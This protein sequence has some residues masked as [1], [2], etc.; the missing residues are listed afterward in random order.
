MATFFVRSSN[1]NT[2]TA[3]L[4]YPGVKVEAD[5]AAAA[6]QA[7]AVTYSLPINTKIVVAPDTS[8]VWFSVGQVSPVTPPPYV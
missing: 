5:D 3:H 2:S 4:P 7:F 1:Q 6:A 8:L